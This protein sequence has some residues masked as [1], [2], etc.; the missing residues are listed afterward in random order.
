VPNHHRLPLAVGLPLA[1][2]AGVCMPIQG[3]ING[4]LGARLDDGLAAAVVSFSTG[5]VLLAALCLLLPA[6]RR[7]LRRVVPALRERKFPRWYLLAGCSGAFLVLSQAETVALIGIAL[8]TVAVVTGQTVSGL[9]VDRLGWGPGGR[10]PVT[11]IRV[12]S[13]V[14]TV[15]AVAWAVSP[16]LILGGPAGAWLLPVLLPLAAGFLQSFQQALNGVQ[17][18]HYRSPWPA[19]LIN[20]VV[21]GALLWAAWGIKVAIAGVGNPLPAEWWYYLGGPIGCVF[22]ALAAVLV[23]SLGVLQTGL[24][25]ISGQIL[26]SLLLDLTVPAPG[27]VITTATVLGTLLTLLAAVLGTLPWRRRDFRNG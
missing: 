25:M 22:I 11:G 1:V 2:A 5:L 19:T 16:K 27:T 20:F 4:A 24:G 9:L 10:S 21:G 18:M 8:F 3:R 6:A 7:G 17:T 12:I 13:A 23:R 26:G 14:L 15:L